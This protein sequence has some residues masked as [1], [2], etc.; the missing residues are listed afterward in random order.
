M[1]IRAIWGC[2]QNTPQVRPTIIGHDDQIRVQMRFGSS[3]GPVWLNGV[4]SIRIRH[5]FLANHA[6]EVTGGVGHEA[7]R[8]RHELDMDAFRPVIWGFMA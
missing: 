6:A 5:Q 1:L 7:Q 8:A 4:D 2:C 3:D